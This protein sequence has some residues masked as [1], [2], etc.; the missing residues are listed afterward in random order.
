M[1]YLLAVLLSIVTLGA[2]DCSSEAATGPAPSPAAARSRTALHRKHRR[3]SLLRHVRRHPRRLATAHRVRLA[4]RPARH[5][6]AVRTVR[7]SAL[8]GTSAGSTAEAARLT[9]T[10]RTSR[11]SGFTGS[12][13]TPGSGGGYS[14]LTSPGMSGIGSTGGGFNPSGAFVGLGHGPSTSSGPSSSGGGVYEFAPGRRRPGSS[15]GSGPSV[16][17]LG[18][19]STGRLGSL[20]GYPGIG[21]SPFSFPG[22]S[23]MM[24]G[25]S[26]GGRVMGP[27]SGM[28]GMS[29]MFGSGPGR[30]R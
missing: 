7:T 16:G 14:Y 22:R 2:T 30:I 17:S 10:Y 20:P 18:R 21:S 25:S 15:T 6:R 3:V 27:G 11:S 1:R 13:Y 23:G 24:A 26:M 29:P 5:H 19:P 4:L 9:P 12:L 8:S 28:S